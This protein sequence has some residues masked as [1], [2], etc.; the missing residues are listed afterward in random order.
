MFRLFIVVF[1]IGTTIQLY[2]AEI[3]TS[4]VSQHQIISLPTPQNLSLNAFGQWIIGW[5]TGAEGARQRLDNIQPE[6][7]TVI[8]QKGTTLDMIKV[9]QQYYEQELENNFENPTARYR[10]RL[11]KRIADLW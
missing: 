6:D 4:E 9:W 8:K 1:L 11:M 3:E 7:V 2:A 10:A 5:G